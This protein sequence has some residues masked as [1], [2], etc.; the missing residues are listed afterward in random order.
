VTKTVVGDD[1]IDNECVLKTTL[2]CAAVKV[3]KTNFVTLITA[4]LGVNINLLAS[5]KI[6]ED[7]GQVSSIFLD[8]V[9]VVLLELQAVKVAT[10][11]RVLVC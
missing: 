3:S 6:L 2:I 10:K 9:S 11:N 7:A 5:V 8:S 4:S 1:Q